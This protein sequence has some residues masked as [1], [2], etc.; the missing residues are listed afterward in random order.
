[1]ELE[2]NIFNENVEYLKTA[3]E[4]LE[5]LDNMKEALDKLYQEERKIQRS[6]AAEDKSIQ[7]EI[8]N[9][10]RTRKS[11]LESVYDKEL[12]ALRDKAKRLRAKRDKKK[13]LKMNER[14]EMETS[15]IKEENDLLGVEL[16]T[17]F[18]QDHVPGFCSSDLYYALFLPRGVKNMIELLVTI[19]ICLVALPAL[20]CFVGSYTFLLE[21]KE[22]NLYYTII[23]MAFIIFFLVIYV[24]VS[25]RTKVLHINALKEGRKI[26][27]IM[28]A[29]NKKIKAIINAINKDTDESHYGLDGYDKKIQSL[30]QE[31]KDIVANK[32]MA[33][34]S[35]END[36]KKL[37]VDE[38]NS[39]RKI[40]L[41]QMKQDYKEIEEEFS[42]GESAIQE[43]TLIV[44]KKYETYLGKEF[45]TFESLQDLIAI[46]EEGEA[47]T[48]SE[49]I[50]I[51]RS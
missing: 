34:S 32:Q 35:F 51:Y 45:T 10:L 49:A 30:E 29:N 23:F 28:R 47:K 20:V 25:N 16:K 21:I 50:A 46:M 3:L 24:V 8:N 37:I 1:M 44:S 9:T 41:D 38:I 13:N 40:I 4:D 7:D 31:G 15:D 39:R 26:K 2:N 27:D 19:L 42:L 5:D 12:D 48:V 11:E 18:K 22:L 17:L 36:T 33:L 14:A 43:M 6:I